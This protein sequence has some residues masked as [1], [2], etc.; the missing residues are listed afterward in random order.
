MRLPE[1]ILKCRI[2]TY[3]TG[4]RACQFLEGKETICH[5]LEER[6][7]FDLPLFREKKVWKSC[8]K[9]DFLDVLLNQH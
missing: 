1:T 4:V 5:D 9:R 3:R 8:G 6:L 7:G 2:R